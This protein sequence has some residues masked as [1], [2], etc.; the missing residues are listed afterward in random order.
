MADYET[1]DHIDE[2]LSNDDE[3]NLQILTRSDNIIKSFNENPE[4]FAE[5]MKAIC[6]ECCKEFLVLARQYRGNQIQKNKVGPFCSRI[7]SGKRNQRLK[8]QPA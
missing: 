3:N 8:Y 7:C 5:Y 6:F 4:R 1:V 2:D